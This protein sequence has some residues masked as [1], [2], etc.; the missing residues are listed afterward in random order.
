MSG[1]C[2]LSVIPYGSTLLLVIGC[3]EECRDRVIED[4]SHEQE[5]SVIKLSYNCRGKIT[6]WI[7][8]FGQI[9]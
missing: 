3:V 4:H 8:R 6:T 1:E 5:F 9:G 2:L 7:A